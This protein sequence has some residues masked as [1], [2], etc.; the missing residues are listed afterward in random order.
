[1]KKTIFIL[2]VSMSFLSRLFGSQELDFPRFCEKALNDLRTKSSA[3]ESL[4]GL[5]HAERWDL[6]QDDGRLIFTFPDKIVT[7]DAQ[8]I[9]TWHRTSATWRWAWSNKTIAEK[10]TRQSQKIQAYGTSR[11]IEKLTTEKWAGTEEDAWQMAALACLIGDTQG[12]Y[13]GPAGDTLVFIAFGEPKI[14]KR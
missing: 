1:M 14:K 11:S 10:L 5:G 6:N 13:R 12:I 8:I 3:H 9:G 7:C 4:W 2:A